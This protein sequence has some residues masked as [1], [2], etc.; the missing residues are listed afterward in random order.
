MAIGQTSLFDTV[1]P[2]VIVLVRQHQTTGADL[3][4]IT[5]VKP[6]FPKETLRA[7]I[8]A[9][10]RELGVAPRGVAIVPHVVGGPKKMTFLRA[11]FAVDGLIERDL[12]ALRVEPILKAFAGVPEPNT[13]HGIN[14]VFDGEAPSKKTLETYQIPD[15][16]RAE[17]RFMPVPRGIEYRIELLSQDPNA[18]TFPEKFEVANEKPPQTTSVPTDNRVVLIV[19]FVIAG[20]ALGALV[21][22]AMLRGGPRKPTTR[23]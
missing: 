5:L 10:G 4:Q 21:Y 18:I 11:E 6:D 7:Q 17:G 2:D 23:R 3:V 19:L 14:I 13:I 22:F 1:K 20:L 16:L 15:V 9:I 8:E 12:S